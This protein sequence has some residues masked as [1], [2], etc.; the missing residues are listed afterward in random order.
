MN[1]NPKF[2]EYAVA[3][4]A[5]F[6]SVCSLFIY[7]YQSKIMA[8][9]Q[10]VA[11]WPRVQWSRSNVQGFEFNVENKGVGPALV[12]KVQMSFNGMPVKGNS[13]L[14]KTVMGA[15][16]AI[17]WQNSTMEGRA[18]SPGENATLFKI[19]DDAEAKLFNDKLRAGKFAME[20]TYC[21]I[22]GRCWISSGFEAKRAPDDKSI[23]Y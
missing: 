9:Q 20:I 21:S 16:R 22:Y 18:L 11:V 3:G 13:E 15:E 2:G 8:E 1:I 12:R 6:V 19:A 14:V 4:T 5:F 23:D 17:A 10:Q 7:I